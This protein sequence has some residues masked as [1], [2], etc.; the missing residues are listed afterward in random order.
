MHAPPFDKGDRPDEEESRVD[1][2]VRLAKEIKY[3]TKRGR[4]DEC[5]GIR[6]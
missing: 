4:E 5:A 3:G 2:G 1:Y 6:G